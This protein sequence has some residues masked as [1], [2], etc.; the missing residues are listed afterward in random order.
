MYAMK[1][2]AIKTTLVF[3]YWRNWTFVQV[4]TD[5]GLIGLGEATLRSREYAVVG[6]IEDMSRYLIGQ[7]PFAIQSHFQTLYKDFHHRGGAV[8]MTAISGIE[9]ALWDILG[10]NYQM[11]IYQLLGGKVRERVWTYANGWFEGV[12]D[13]DQLIRRAQE[14]VAQGFTALKWNPFSG[15]DGW[16]S[17]QAMRKAI[18]QIEKIREAVGDDV[19][20][21]LEAHGLFTPAMAIRLAGELEAYRPYWLE[22]PVPPEDI[23]GMAFV[24][25]QSSIPIASGER[26]YTKYQ[27]ADLIEQR[28]VDI[29]QP[30]VQHAGGLLEL[31]TIAAMGEARYMGFAPHNSSSPVGTA[32][33]LHLGACVPNFLIQELP[34]GD[35]P[36]RD[37]I[38]E[39]P[40]E[41]ITDGYLSLPTMPGLGVRLNEKVAKQHPYQNPDLSALDEAAT[42]ESQQLGKKLS[43]TTK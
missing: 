26:L 39:P 16:M 5:Q 13:E 29:L 25:S 15:A 20:L 27:F 19:E 1:I 35:V 18:R 17:P 33:S 24:H 7:D 42:P 30:D 2:T 31:R 43:K 36:W 8:L 34:V 4:F 23:G 3:A 38:V 41:Q 14:A 37:E 6:A 12:V 22:E 9:I 40:I 21:M 28:A 11:P 32:A 10:Q